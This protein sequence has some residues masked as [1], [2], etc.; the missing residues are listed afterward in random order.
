MTARIDPKLAEQLAGDPS[1]QVEAIITC[2]GGLDAALADLPDGVEVRH[3][4]RRINGA[5]VRGPASAVVMVAD[6]R[7]VTKMEPVRSVST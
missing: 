2:T 6:V 3:T 5:A 1:A 4:Y 7:G